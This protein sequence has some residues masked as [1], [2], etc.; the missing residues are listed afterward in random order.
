M[1]PWMY[2]LVFGS[3]VLCDV[4]WTKYMLAVADK[5]PTASGLWSA[6]IVLF[7][8]FNIVTYVHNH[9]ALIP[10]ALGAFLGTW[11]TVRRAK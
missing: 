1:T 8:A 4:A 5:R 3:T 6:G 10:A 11:L 2:L 7:G 9:W